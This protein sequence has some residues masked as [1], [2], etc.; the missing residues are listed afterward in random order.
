MSQACRS[1]ASCCALLQVCFTAF[2]SYKPER[3]PYAQQSPSLVWPKLLFIFFL[4]LP[5]SPFFCFSEFS[6]LHKSPAIH[7]SPSIHHSLVIVTGST[8]PTGKVMIWLD[9][10]FCRAEARLQVN[11]RALGKVGALGHT[12]AAAHPYT[13]SVFQL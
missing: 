5:G 10:R 8:F 13:A 4:L 2:L 11:W 9:P 12:G 1:L 6:Y 7:L 3:L